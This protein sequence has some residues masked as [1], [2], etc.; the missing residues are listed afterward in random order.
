MEGEPVVTAALVWMVVGPLAG[1]A[2]GLFSFKVKSR[3]CRHHGVVK[4]C[5]NCIHDMPALR[6]V[7]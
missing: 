4:I 3:W 1:F 2:V 5:P 6:R 7:A